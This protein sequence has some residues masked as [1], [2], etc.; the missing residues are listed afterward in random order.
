VVRYLCSR[1][2]VMHL[3]AVV[4]SGEVAKV[5]ADPRH[6][7]TRSLLASI[8]PDDAAA[9]WPAAALRAAEPV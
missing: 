2:L 6:A 1:V 4:E 5:F 3:G 9:A 8:P 7:Y